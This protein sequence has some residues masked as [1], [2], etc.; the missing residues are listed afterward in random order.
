MPWYRMVWF[1]IVFDGKLGT[2]FYRNSDG[3]I[4]FG[5]IQLVFGEYKKFSGDTTNNR[6]LSKYGKTFKF[7]KT[8]K[9][10]I[11]HIF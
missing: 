11:G 5:G 8:F 6:R 3:G 7:W 2:V 9:T 10:G 1:G 4:S